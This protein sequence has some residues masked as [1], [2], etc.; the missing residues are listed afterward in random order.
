[1]SGKSVLVLAL[2]SLAVLLALAWLLL[3]ERAPR[4][5]VTTGV[6]ATVSEPGPAASVA[7]A[8]REPSTGLVALDPARLEQLRTLGARALEAF[9][10]RRIPEEVH[11]YQ[12][13]SER[14]AQTLSPS[15]KLDL[16]RLQMLGP[17]LSGHEDEVLAL[18]LKPALVNHQHLWVL[19]ILDELDTPAARQASLR[20]VL[21]DLEHMTTDEDVAVC[22]RILERL[23]HCTPPPGVEE[24]LP[25]ALA[26]LRVAESP[27]RQMEGEETELFPA[28]FVSYVA[29]AQTPEAT[30]AVR[31]LLESPDER[32]RRFAADGV[33]AALSESDDSPLVEDLRGWAAEVV[34]GKQSNLGLPRL[35]WLVHASAGPA[36]LEALSRIRVPPDDS[37]DWMADHR[38]WT[39]AVLRA[40]EGADP[41]AARRVLHALLE[42][43]PRRAREVAY[44]ERKL[45]FEAVAGLGAREDLELLRQLA[46]RHESDADRLLSEFPAPLWQGHE[47]ILVEL[48]QEL[49]RAGQ[50]GEVQFRLGMAMLVQ[51]GVD[52]SVLDTGAPT[53]QESLAFARRTGTVRRKLDLLSAGLEQTK[54]LA[55]LE[56]MRKLE[57]ALPE[58]REALG[59]A[60]EAMRRLAQEAAAS[61]DGA[62]LE[63][64]LLD[65]K[66]ALADVRLTLLSSF[67]E[68]ERADRTEILVRCLPLL[69]QHDCASSAWRALQAATL[70]AVLEGRAGR[71]AANDVL[72]R[73]EACR[74][75]VVNKRAP[76]AVALLSEFLAMADELGVDRVYGD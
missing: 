12:G 63:R 41:R 74:S 44:E 38:A 50:E 75:E 5:P 36:A 48:L 1:M 10:V 45:V 27:D 32:V 24:F 58:L 68:T 42:D 54:A 66:L 34:G 3:E 59:E 37:P 8:A 61:A 2:G 43:T 21:W 20:L 19:K 17:A 35:A 64:A 11:E 71:A 6:P 56:R 53:F 4:A 62:A 26:C 23:E 39:R 15:G 55:P 47:P 28:R 69:M 65:P 52:P 30:R 40:A 31:E 14:I 7:C 29:H 13:I 46:V 25:R 57:E 60:M 18:V 70:L 72:A 33:I 22:G 76:N 16:G 49:A 73:F 67:A 51:N 9:D